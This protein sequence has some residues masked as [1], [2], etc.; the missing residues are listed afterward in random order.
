[1]LARLAEKALGFE[2]AG[3][4]WGPSEHGANTA[5]GDKKASPK[6]AGGGK[7]GK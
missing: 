6:K 2:L 5:M 7:P 3:R 4:A 1:M